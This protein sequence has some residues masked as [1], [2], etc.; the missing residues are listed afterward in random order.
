MALPRPPAPAPTAAET[1]ES[2]MDR[3]ASEVRDRLTTLGKEN[4]HDGAAGVHVSWSKDPT[5]A[6]C[7]LA[8]ELDVPI[9]FLSV[10]WGGTRVAATM[11]GIYEP[12]GSGSFK[13]TAGTAAFMNW[14]ISSPL[15][16][17]FRI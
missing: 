16:G 13:H 6:L 17:V 15:R 14:R 4:F 12:F 7:N 8:E 5:S 11:E 10:G 9:A 2:A 1:H 3:A